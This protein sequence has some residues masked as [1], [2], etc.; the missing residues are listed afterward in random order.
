MGFQGFFMIIVGI[1]SYM[2][3]FSFLVFW[4]FQSPPGP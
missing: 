4:F 2:L 3:G 1:I